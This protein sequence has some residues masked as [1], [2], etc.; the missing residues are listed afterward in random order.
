MDGGWMEDGWGMG[1]GGWMKG[2]DGYLIYTEGK[3]A[4]AARDQGFV[5]IS[6]QPNQRSS[7]CLLQPHLQGSCAE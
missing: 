2:D 5:P 1:D 7:F 6:T 4:C 3:G